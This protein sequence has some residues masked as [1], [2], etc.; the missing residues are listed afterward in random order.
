MGTFE[1]SFSDECQ[2]ARLYYYDFLAGDGCEEISAQIR[3]HLEGCEHCQE[4]IGQLRDLL[5]RG[6]EDPKRKQHN[7]EMARVLGL[8][9]AF[10][11]EP[12]TCTTVRRFLPS[13]AVPSLQVH[14]PTPITV[15]IDKCKACSDDLQALVDLNLAETQLFRLG[16]LFADKL[17]NHTADCPKVRAIVKQVAAADLSQATAEV[18]K[19]LCLCRDCRITL[20]QCR[21]TLL[22][23]LR[24]KGQPQD[25]YSCE[26][27]T[28]SGIF[29]YCIPYGVD[30][31]AR[32][33]I[34]SRERLAVHLHTCPDCMARVQELHNTVFAIAD[35]ANSGIVTRYELGSSGREQTPTADEAYGD[36]PIRVQTVHQ[37]LISAPE[38]S[39][40]SS[41]TPDA[42]QERRKTGRIL[43]FHRLVKPAIVAAGILIGVLLILNGSTAKAVTLAQVYEALERVKNVCVA[44][45][46]PGKTEPLQKVWTSQTLKMKMYESKEALVLWDIS[47]KT[48]KI[49]SRLSGSVKTITPSDEMLAK[50]EKSIARAVEV[51]PFPKIDAVPEGVVWTRVHDKEQRAAAQGTEVYELAWVDHNSTSHRCLIF[52]DPITQLPKRLEGRRRH[53]GEHEHRLDSVI[54]LTYPTDAQIEATITGEF[55]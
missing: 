51:L 32:H 53:S 7:A 25:E 18:L 43:S 10:I 35:R 8:H 50:Q 5:A 48:Q 4:G 24:H 28:T 33:D 39:G 11:D 37:D 27:I 49:K 26:Q 38:N 47:N 29:D 55:K 1:H 6:A 40:K 44:R 42:P 12:V 20:R 21:E 15:H 14:V 30:P 22:K 31:A 2:D 9:F 19:H 52:L 46:A 45:F 41:S 16:Q 23:E 13:L 17:S 3:A 54:V 34:A 36:W